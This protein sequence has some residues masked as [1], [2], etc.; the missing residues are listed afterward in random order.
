ME[1]TP[2]FLVLATLGPRLEQQ[3]GMF[4]SQKDA[5]SFAATLRAPW[6][7][8]HVEPHDLPVS[9]LHPSHVEVA[10]AAKAVI[11]KRAAAKAAGQ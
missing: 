3:V 9:D 6:K 8:V 4:F 2:V 1:T 5:E 11:E 7:D 10:A